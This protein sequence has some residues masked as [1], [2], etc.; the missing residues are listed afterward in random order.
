MESNYLLYFA[1]LSNTTHCNKLLITLPCNESCFY[2]L[3]DYSNAMNTLS[4]KVKILIVDDHVLSR[5]GLKNM[6]TEQQEN[7]PIIVEA[8]NGAEAINILS[9][10]KFDLVL[11]DLQMPKIDGFTT[12]TALREKGDQT[13]IIIFSF[14]VDELI[15]QRMLNAGANG[16]MSKGI[17]MEDLMLGIN[18]VI[19][20]NHYFDEVIEKEDESFG[21]T[22]NL[23]K[24]E[25]QILKLIAQESS[26]TEIAD[27]LF[28]SVRT[29]EG[30][31]KNLTEKL[32]V[33]GSVGLTK[34]AIKYGIV[35][36]E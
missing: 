28:I 29:V 4:K 16:F 3:N 34:Y 20:G 22:I 14:H 25:W 23:T 32:N 11:L 17:S 35:K 10:N 13:P 8:E 21:L 33:K 1:L 7:C 19:E 30:H 12:L 6:L 2:L 24:R 9:Q 18:S 31:K 36:N 5:Q 27:E 15:V 26:N